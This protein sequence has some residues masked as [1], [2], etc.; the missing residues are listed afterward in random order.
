MSWNWIMKKILNG[1]W[2]ELNTFLPQKSTLTI[3]AAVKSWKIS[4]H[5]DSAGH[6]NGLY[7]KAGEPGLNHPQCWLGW[8]VFPETHNITTWLGILPQFLLLQQ[9][10]MLSNGSLLSTWFHWLKELSF[11]RA[12]ATYWS[13]SVM[14]RFI[15]FSQL[16]SE[17]S[18]KGFL[19]TDL[20]SLW[21]YI[22]CSVEGREGMFPLQI[23]TGLGSITVSMQ[24]TFKLQILKF[25]SSI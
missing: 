11:I 6:L 14:L 15:L 2:G 5:R 19:N 22:K 17:C 1:I 18:V 12:R 3:F 21:K 24:I 10:P 13:V 9:Y 23:L 8:F 7:A 4:F 16:C 20:G 25:L